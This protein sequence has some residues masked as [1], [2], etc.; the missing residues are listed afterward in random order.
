MN[1]RISDD[2]QMTTYLRKAKLSNELR[3]GIHYITVSVDNRQ[4]CPYPKFYAR[5]VGG[6]LVYLYLVEN[7]VTGI[8]SGNYSFPV[9]G[10]YTLETLFYGCQK[11][12]IIGSSGQSG[13][14]ETIRIKVVETP[15]GCRGT[16]SSEPL[17]PSSCWLRRNRSGSVSASNLL[18]VDPARAD[19]SRVTT[20]DG[21]VVTES[22]ATKEH[23]FYQFRS[24]SNYELLCF[25]GNQTMQE[26]RREFLEIR[27][28]IFGPQRPF[29]FHMY[30]MAGFFHRPDRYWSVGDKQRIRKCKH[31][32]VNMEELE[33]SLSQQ[34]YRNQLVIFVGH[35]LK[36]MN[37]TTFPI[38]L[39]TWMQPPNQATNCHH[40][41]LNRTT[42]HPCNDVLK[43]LFPP[44]P[45]IFPPRVQLLDNTDITLPLL[46]EGRSF[47]AFANVALRV[48][49]VAGHQVSKWRT[50]GQHGAIDGLH[51]NGKVEPNF[52]IVAYEG[53]T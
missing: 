45:P 40:P 11:E 48:Y 39:F 7:T 15:E 49:A 26:I 29:K 1:F 20:S 25:L 38:R 36:L 3:L 21:A 44:N 23:G 6:S 17:F 32:L 24:L 37:D 13:P 41:F 47:Q 42:D 8:W 34:E 43:G 27:P 35:L 51:R 31:I 10:W 30:N 33:D 9:P 5:F 16:S 52:D 4:K 28:Q 12:S 19:Q 18:W 22:V 50:A 53:W 14:L 46:H 2:L